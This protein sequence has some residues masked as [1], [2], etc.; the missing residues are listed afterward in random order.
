MFV[1]YLARHESR[2]SKP[3]VISIVFLGIETNSSGAAMAA[4]EIRNY[5]EDVTLAPMVFVADQEEY[6]TIEDPSQRPTNGWRSTYME[7]NKEKYH[8]VNAASPLKTEIQSTTGLTLKKGDATRMA[9]VKPDRSFRLM[10][11]C[12]RLAVPRKSGARHKLETWNDAA[13]QK[14]GLPLFFKDHRWWSLQISTPYLPLEVLEKS[15][16]ALW[17][18]HHF[19]YSP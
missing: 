9:F 6:G 12:T 4:F 14:V 2:A 11:D 7:G 10:V 19:E 5:A 3:P 15:G 16:N 8:A 1:V 13:H 17:L 18:D